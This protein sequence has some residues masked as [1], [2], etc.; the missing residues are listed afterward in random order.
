MTFVE[1]RREIGEQVLR[2]VC[3]VFAK[4][5]DDIGDVEGLEMEIKLTDNILVCVPHRHVPRN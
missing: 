2:E 5:D 4:S 1:K 3:E